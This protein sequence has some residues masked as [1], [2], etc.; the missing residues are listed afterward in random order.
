MSGCSFRVHAAPDA[1][2]TAG[3]ADARPP[4]AP[5]IPIDAAMGSLLLTGATVSGDINLTQEGLVDWTQWGHLGTSGA[6]RKAAANQISELAATPVNYA[7]PTPVTESW[8]D[9]SPDAVVTANH[10]AVLE[11]AGSDMDFTAP[12]ETATHTLRVYVGVQ[13]SSARVDAALSDS[14]APAAS[15]TLMGD[16]YECF[17]I[18]YRAAQ[19]G[20]TIS[21][22]L[23]DTADTTGSN[24]FTMLLAATLQ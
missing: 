23:T 18:T 5:I 6:E 11:N 24:H 7:G 20:Q 19:A 17:T 22:R 8:T 3:S 4:D 10:D 2:L 14:S 16:Q 9:G 1:S 12:A 15:M 13:G 21:V